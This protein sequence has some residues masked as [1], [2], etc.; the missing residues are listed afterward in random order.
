MLASD[1]EGSAEEDAAV[2][3]FA[4]Q[5]EPISDETLAELRRCACVSLKWSESRLPGDKYFRAAADLCRTGMRDVHFDKLDVEQV[6]GWHGIVLGETNQCKRLKAELK[7]VREFVKSCGPLEMLIARKD[8]DVLSEAD[9]ILF[10]NLQ[11]LLQT[12][13]CGSVTRS[14]PKLAVS[15]IAVA[16][17][18]IREPSLSVEAALAAFA[19]R[20]P[21]STA[22]SSHS[23]D[24]ALK[25]RTR[26]NVLATRDRISE[27]SLLAI[28]A[29]MQL[30]C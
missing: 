3:S 27:L 10:D 2:A 20:P 5:P 15:T 28:P 30:A 25:H 14:R 12:Q 24:W 18:L 8:A 23:R 22:S 9:E 6:C 13:M 7:V 17:C 29:R 26:E 16:V 1:E 21:L 11:L 4:R 19:A